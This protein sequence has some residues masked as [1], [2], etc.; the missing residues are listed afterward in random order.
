M[1]DAAAGKLFNSGSMRP[2][3]VQRFLA[4]RTRKKQKMCSREPNAE[5]L[6]A[7]VD[8]P[9]LYFDEM[10]NRERHASLAETRCRR[11]DRRHV[12]S[13]RGEYATSLW[14]V[15]AFCEQSSGEYPF[16]RSQVISFSIAHFL[17]LFVRMSKNPGSPLRI[18]D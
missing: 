4:D 14:S 9:A 7:V 6:R 15:P 11:E 10:L 16:R 1:A 13:N 17:C 8:P 3:R 2:K 18:F 5:R 12:V